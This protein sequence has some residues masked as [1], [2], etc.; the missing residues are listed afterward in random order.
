MVSYSH[1]GAG[2]SAFKHRSYSNGKTKLATK[3][4]SRHPRLSKYFNQRACQG[5]R[6]WPAEC[7]VAMA[8]VC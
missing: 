1:R 4:E 8:S 7:Y 5:I 2:G 3:K 6:P